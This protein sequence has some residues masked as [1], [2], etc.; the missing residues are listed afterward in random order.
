MN[1]ILVVN[2][3]V[4]TMSLLKSYLELKA[5][6]VEYT[7][8]RDEAMQMVEEFHPGLVIVDVLQ[9]E[10]IQPLK[11]NKTTAQVP[12]LLMSGYSLRSKDFETGADDVIEKPFD[13]A[14]LNTKIEKHLPS[15]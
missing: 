12:I 9:K 2:N 14:I 6:E 5:Y 7:S 11:E 8:S 4:E 15:I 10:I 3:D 13:L 1:K